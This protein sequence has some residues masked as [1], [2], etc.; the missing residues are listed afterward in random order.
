MPVTAKEAADD[1]LKRSRAMLDHAR[2]RNPALKK[3][4]ARQS[5]VMAVAALDTYLH[6]LILKRFG[7]HGGTLPKA[8]R[9][10]DIPLGEA[11][12]MADLQKKN[13][14]EGVQGRPWT[15]VRRMA[16]DRLRKVPL[17][18]ARAV[19]DAYNMA[20][21][22][23]VWSIARKSMGGSANGIKVRLGKIV[24]RRNQIVHEGDLRRLVRPQ[25]IKYNDIRIDDTR[26]DIDWMDKFI[27]ALHGD[28]QA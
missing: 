22:T 1:V 26:A 9:D 20:G 21:G 4:L 3:D 13:Q 18:G 12:E 14:Q 10:L 5:L 11:A 2:N 16:A 8:L 19:E 7:D 23:K 25:S 15:Q 6:W 27:Q 17:Q 24:N 28:M